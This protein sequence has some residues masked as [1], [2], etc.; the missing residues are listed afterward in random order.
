MRSACISFKADVP[1]DYKMDIE[2]EKVPNGGALGGANCSEKWPLGN[3]RKHLQRSTETD[4]RTQTIEYS[5]FS[6]NREGRKTCQLGKK[7]ACY[8]L[9]IHGHHSSDT[10]SVSA[11]D[12]LQ[13]AHS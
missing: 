10:I 9:I 4:F 5:K 2:T 8:P 11:A 1:S 13:S 12:S 6:R 7:R 3:R